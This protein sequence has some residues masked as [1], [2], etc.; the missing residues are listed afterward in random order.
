M[1]QL[2]MLLINEAKQEK[3]LIYSHSGQ[4]SIQVRNNQFVL[5]KQ[6]NAGKMCFGGTVGIECPNDIK[7]RVSA[8]N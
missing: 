5:L 1:G 3:M 6:S 4:I 2:K 8:Y 7:K